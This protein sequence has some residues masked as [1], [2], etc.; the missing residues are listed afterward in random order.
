MNDLPR[1][2]YTRRVIDESLRLYQPAWGIWRAPTEDDEISGHPIPARAFV[3]LSAYV[4]HRHPDFWENP[5]GFDPE[6]CTPERLAARPHSAYFLCAGG[7]RL[8]IG[9]RFALQ[10]AP[11]VL[12]AVAPP[13]RPDPAACRWC[14]GGLRGE[15]GPRR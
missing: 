15:R 2:L 1:L 8:R 11:L 5:E 13:Y 4:T 3:L 9:N 7:S 10:E 6:R 14:S 12:A